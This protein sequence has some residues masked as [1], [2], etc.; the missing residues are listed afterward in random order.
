[1]GIIQLSTPHIQLSFDEIC[2]VVQDF[3]LTLS[4]V[5]QVRKIFRITTPGGSVFALKPTKLSDQDLQFI[6]SALIHLVR[7]GFPV[8]P[9]IPVRSGYLSTRVQSTQFILLPWFDGR[10]AD[11][12]RMGELMFGTKLLARL[13]RSSGFHPDSVPQNRHLWGAWS[14]RFTTRLDQMSEFLQIAADRKPIFDRL[15]RRHAPEFIQQAYLAIEALN[16]SPYMTICAMEQ[17]Q[18]Y[19]CHHD[20]SD[21]NILLRPDSCSLLDFDYCLCD[22]RL[23]DLAN[24]I[25]RI[26][27]HDQWQ[28]ERPF[29]ILK[30]YHRQFPLTP[31]HLRVLH[32]FLQWPQDFWQVGLQYYVE[33]QEWPEARFLKSIR[34]VI[35]NEPARQRFLRLFPEENGLARFTPWNVRTGKATF[36]SLSTRELPVSILP[37]TNHMFTDSGKNLATR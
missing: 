27:R 7:T 18:A 13:H 2:S 5:E 3:G 32:A 21:R 17:N 26:L 20:F 25:L 23:H 8:L 34:R 33:K 22:L 30:V 24:L 4:Q 10:E 35:E 31:N 28:P 16:I 19:L 29:F 1:M 37:G 36:Y 15:Y 14:Q 12:N 9:L 6:Q 11:F